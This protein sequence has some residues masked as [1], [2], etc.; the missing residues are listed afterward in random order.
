MQA[1]DDSKNK[2]IF[3]FRTHC[4]F[5]YCKPCEKDINLHSPDDQCAFNRAGVLCGG[6]AKNYSLAIGFSNCPNNNNLALLIFF[7]V[8]GILLVLIVVALNLTVTQ[9]IINGLIF[10]VNIIWAYQIS[11]FHLMLVES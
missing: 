10:Y 8:A 3:H 2:T 9:G 6:C 11:Y 1:M 5:S 7:V 4:P